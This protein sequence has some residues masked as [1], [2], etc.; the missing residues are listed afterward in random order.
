MVRTVA[1]RRHVVR[2]VLGALGALLI[3][4]ALPALPAAAAVSDSAGTDGGVLVRVAGDVAVP[5]S[6]S[7]D[8]VVVVQGDLSLEGKVEVVVVVDGTAALTGATVGTLVVVGGEAVLRDGT[9]VTGDVVLPNSTMDRD[10]SSRI[11]GEVVT[12]LSG[13]QR[14]LTF[15]NIVLAVGGALLTILAA[16]LLAAIAPGTVR[17]AVTAIRADT[18]R[19]AIGGLVFWLAL[20]LAAV[21][22]L[23]TVVGAPTA[24]AIW[25]L[26]LPAVAFAGYIVSAIW[27][28]QLIVDRR[29]ERHHPYVAALV[30]TALLLAVGLIPF[31][32]GLVGFAAAIVGGSALALTAWRSFRSGPSAPVSAGPA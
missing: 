17:S 6:R 14:A 31:L 25:L 13:F 12:D 23:L 8:V 22:L 26:V 18:G 11:D 21:P 27:I 2:S 29:G 10:G 7:V 24:L 4:A 16:L 30:G 32:G 19:V 28:G 5:A 20:P 15:V 9:V 3:A 1:R